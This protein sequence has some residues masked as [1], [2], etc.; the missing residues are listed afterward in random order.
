MSFGGEIF[1][2]DQ[3]LVIT[4]ALCNDVCL[5]PYLKLQCIQP[6]DPPTPPIT[7]T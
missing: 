3:R 4:V 7:H 5:S 6:P 2:S 1:T